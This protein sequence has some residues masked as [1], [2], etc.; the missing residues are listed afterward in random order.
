MSA[1]NLLRDLEIIHL[2][3]SELKGRYRSHPGNVLPTSA[4]RFLGRLA[5]NGNERSPIAIDENNRILAGHRRQRRAIM[6]GLPTVPCIRLTN[7][8]D[9]QKQAANSRL[10]NGPDGLD[11]RFSD[12]P[13][14]KRIFDRMMAALA[15]VGLSPLLLVLA[16]LVR[17]D[18]GP[19]FYGQRRI[20][21]YGREFHCWKFRTMVVNADKVLEDMLAR[22]PQARAE[23]DRDF[24]LKTD[25]RVTKI[26][27]FLRKTSLDELPQLFNI[28]IGEMSL[29]GPRPITM[30]E[31]KFY[32]RHI[33]EYLSVHPGL[34]GLWQVSGRNDV[35]YDERVALDKHYVTKWSF[36]QDLGIIFKT[37]PVMLHRSGAY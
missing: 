18:G 23:W 2:S 24:K 28:L 26:G 17:S 25:P 3:P 33:A 21:R 31:V 20:A 34:T 19:V 22:D 11:L 4:M 27:L 14:S 30:G 12:T 5:H 36:R 8:D 29:V 35:S 7:L 9:E 32:G 1:I 37:I 13:F 6:Y 10:R 15:I 16:L